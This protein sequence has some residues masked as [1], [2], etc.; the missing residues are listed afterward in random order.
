MDFGK[1]SLLARFKNLFIIYGVIIVIVLLAFIFGTRQDGTMPPAVWL[2]V[3]VLLMIPLTIILMASLKMM[4]VVDDSNS[5]L[6]KVTDELEKIRQVVIQV[7]QCSH[8]SES[9][10]VIAFRDSD[11]QTLRDAVFDKLQQ[12]DF[13]AAYEIIDE[14]AHRTGYSKLAEQLHIQ[15]DKYR[16]ATDAERMNQLIAHIEKHLDDHQWAKASVQIERLIKEYPA[17]EKALALRQRLIEKKDERKKILL[18]AWDDAVKRQATDRSI[19]I[20]RE[21]DQYLTP[22]EG[23]ALQEAARD[24]FRNKLHNLGVQFSLAISGGQWAKALE[25]GMEIIRDFPNSR[26]AEEIREKIDILETHAQQKT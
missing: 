17:S 1:D 15:A 22:N 25:T 9:A 7:N 23:L 13:E 5:K 26:M 16:D 3:V 6:E 8:L 24:V 18:N 11:T 21:L 14:I 20:L 10:K 12:K 2:L 4:D 19:E